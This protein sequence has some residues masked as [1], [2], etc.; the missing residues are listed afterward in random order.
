MRRYISN[1]HN[2]TILAIVLLVALLECRVAEAIQIPGLPSLE[3]VDTVPFLNRHCEN[4]FIGN[5]ILGGGGD[6]KGT[7]NFLIGPDYTSPNFLKSEILTITVNGVEKVLV[8]SMHRI[9][10]S[11]IFYDRV[12][13][14]DARIHVFEY[15]TPGMPLITRHFVIENTSENHMLTFQVHAKIQKGNGIGDGVFGEALLLNADGSSPLF[16]NGD[17]GYWKE[18]F[19]LIAFSPGNQC[20]ISLS[21]ADLSSAK[22]TVAPGQTEQA[23]LV[24]CLFDNDPKLTK[25]NLHRIESLD[26]G[27]NLRTSLEEWK[28]WIGKGKKIGQAD[29]RVNDIL[30]SMLVGIRMQQN[31]CGGFIAGT[32]KYAFSYI[33]DSYGA[34]KGLLACGHTEEVKKYIEITLHK[35]HI[36]NKIPNSVQMGADKFSHGDGNQFAESPAYVLLL[37]KAYYAATGD[38]I[39]LKG[40][41]EM[42][43]FAVDIQL[44]YAK[45]NSWLLP[46]NGDETEQYCVKEDGMEYGG[47]PALTGFYKDQWSM[48]S[49]AACISSLKFYIDYLEIVK[50]GISVKEYQEA[51]TMMKKSLMEHFYRPEM[52]GLQWALKKDGTYYSYNVTNFVLM[53]VWFGLSLPENAEKEAVRNTL[54]F[55]NPSTGF[56][57]DAPGDVEGF[58][59]HTLAFLLYDLTRL[60]MPEKEA[61]FNAMVNSCIIQRYGMVNE[62]YGP[63]GIPNPHNLRVFESGVV[64]D[65]LVEYLKAAKQKKQAEPSKI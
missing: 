22:I 63:N 55:I 52:G 3:A 61:V 34:C 53:P 46:F 42:L 8:L 44:E 16:G 47:F 27:K 4:Y 45:K 23:G 31:R 29:A 25:E 48:S 40:L 43:K 51:A 28:S 38:I 14:G 30:E 20:G 15:A 36:F 17:G 2:C 26:L 64:M 32:R 35:F 10:T 65:A 33:R 1:N 57:A 13:A 54:S 5:G 39:F 21:S 60:E 62:Y 58:C 6:E 56:I 49:A 24:H 18:S 50:P 12:E 9:R 11:G 41:D 19:A 37:A 7:W 59:G